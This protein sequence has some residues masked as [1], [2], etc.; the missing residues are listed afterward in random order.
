MAALPRNVC[1][2]DVQFSSNQV[3]AKWV[4]YF[5]SSKFAGFEF[6]HDIARGHDDL[7]LRECVSSHQSGEP[8]YCKD[9]DVTPIGLPHVDD[10]SFK[11]QARANVNVRGHVRG[12][13]MK[14]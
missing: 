2:A 8:Y 1:F 5:A 11:E 14:M 6:E 12:M 3:Q 13:C 7:R 4:L 9:Y 10:V